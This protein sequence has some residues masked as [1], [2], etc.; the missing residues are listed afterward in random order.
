M[1]S[2]AEIGGIVCINEPAGF[3]VVVSALQVIQ[4]GFAIVVIAAVADGVPV[5][6]VIGGVVDN[7]EDLAP[8]IVGVLCFQSAVGSVN[9]GNIALQ[10]LAE[11]VVRVVKAKANNAAA[12]VVVGQGLA[13]VGLLQKLAA[14]Y[15]V[16]GVVLPTAD[17]VRAIGKGVA[18]EGI[19]LTHMAPAQDVAPVGGGVTHGIVYAGLTV[20]GGHPVAP[21]GGGV[22]VGNR[23][24]CAQ[25]KIRRQRIGALFYS[26]YTIIFYISQAE[27]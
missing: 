13:A 4:L 2:S 23:F 16:D 5:A 1:V 24:V 21:A 18:I 8:G 10:I 19:Q 7:A 6:D 25:V 9:G 17:A 15:G 3:G 22:D 20:I 26:D 27:K 14:V 12:A 11:E